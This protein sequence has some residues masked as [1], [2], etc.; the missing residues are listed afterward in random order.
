MNNN[1]NDVEN[2]T[3]NK[4]RI[5][6]DTNDLESSFEYESDIPDDGSDLLAQQQHRCIRGCGLV[7]VHGGWFH[8]CGRVDVHGCRADAEITN[9]LHGV[10]LLILKTL[11]LTNCFIKMKGQIDFQC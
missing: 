11:T 3:N 7:R 6:H 10:I 2:N 8:R 9:L 4:D 1:N 5:C